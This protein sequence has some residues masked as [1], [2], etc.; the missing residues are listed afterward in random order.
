MSGKGGGEFTLVVVVAPASMVVFGTHVDDGV[1]G[2]EDSGVAGADEKGGSVRGEQ[3]KHGDS[4]SLIGV[5]MAIVRPNEW[6]VLNGG[7]SQHMW[8]SLKPHD[9]YCNKQDRVLLQAAYA[10]VG[11]CG[12][13]LTGLT[14]FAGFSA[15]M[16]RA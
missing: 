15:A 8:E 12:C 9:L 10:L 2:R 4:E 11:P 5:K 7:K 16:V 14:F 6:L 1:A 13:K 3:P